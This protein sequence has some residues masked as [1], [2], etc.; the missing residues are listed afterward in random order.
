MS[1]FLGTDFILENAPESVLQAAKKSGRVGP[2]I[3]IATSK[4]QGI[5]DALLRRFGSRSARKNSMQKEATLAGLF[6]ELEKIGGSLDIASKA[7]TG[8]IG[9]AVQHPGA[10]Y[11][12]YKQQKKG[13]SKHEQTML[14][15]KYGYP[16]GWVA[17]DMRPE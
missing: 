11:W 1:D 12:R 16:A 7:A 9:K 8:I 17:M 14:A 10:S 5:R 3:D 2:L 4:T 15:L 6:D 13:L